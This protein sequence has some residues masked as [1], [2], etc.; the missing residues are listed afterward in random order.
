[1]SK[2]SDYSKFDHIDS[3]DERD[4]AGVAQ[5]VLPQQEGMSP[6][7]ISAPTAGGALPSTTG[8]ATMYRNEETGRYSFMYNG[9]EVYQ[10]EQTLDDVTIYVTAPPHVTKGNQ[11][12][13]Q[14]QPTHLKLGLTGGSQ[15]FLD[16]PTFGTVD[17]SE[18]TWSLEDEGRGKVITIYLTKAHRGELW[19]A[20]LKGSK[21]VQL[22]PKAKE[23]A[24]KKLMLERFQ[25]EHPGFD[26]RD[27]EFNG[28]VPDARS[29]MGGVKPS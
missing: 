16:E 19:D 18:S 3:D 10:W 23:D 27:A 17:S 12:L 6:P 21:A 13:V 26:F 28:G 8:T 14:I 11:V 25:E 7:V 29:F 22:D 1:M 9:S 24:K 2:L 4:S 5:P 20:A 15:W